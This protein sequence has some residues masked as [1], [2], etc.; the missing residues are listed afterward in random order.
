MGNYIKINPHQEYY[1]T[2][3]QI[4]TWLAAVE[5]ALGFKLFVWQKVYIEHG[6]FRRFGKTTA[7]ILRDLSQIDKPPLDLR[8]YRTK[9]MRE[10]LYCHELLRMKETLDAAGVPTREV[11]LCENDRRKWIQKQNEA[12]KTQAASIL[13]EPLRPLGKFWDI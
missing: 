12:A 4:E 13:E 2:S 9:N 10:R 6:I 5:A 11:W 7:E 1:T 3:A 8:R